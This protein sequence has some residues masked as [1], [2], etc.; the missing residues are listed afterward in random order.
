[1]PYVAQRKFT[2]FGQGFAAPGNAYD[3]PYIVPAAMLERLPHRSL[4]NMLSRGAIRQ[5]EAVMID[6]PSTVTALPVGPQGVVDLE[7]DPRVINE[8]H[9]WWLVA[10]NRVHG[11]TGAQKRLEELGG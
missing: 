5:V 8:G 2:M 11:R 9:G 4:N 3:L 6:D 10:G 1:M 7:A